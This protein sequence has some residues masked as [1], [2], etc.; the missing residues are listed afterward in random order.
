MVITKG[1]PM[2]VAGI[3]CKGQGD[4]SVNYAR[5]IAAAAVHCPE[6]AECGQYGTINVQLDH[7]IDKGKADCWTPVVSWKPVRFGNTPQTNFR[8]EE[9]GFTAINLEYPLDGPLYPA[10]MIFPSGHLATYCNGSYVEII[11][12]QLIG[13]NLIGPGNLCAIYID[14]DPAVERPLSFGANWVSWLPAGSKR[15]W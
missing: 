1:S 15:L 14:H 12:S 6:V 8:D 3:T 9:F 5:Q 11:A 10:F 2:R 7:P 4:A 13:G